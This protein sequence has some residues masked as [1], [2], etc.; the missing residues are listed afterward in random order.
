MPLDGTGG[1]EWA[2]SRVERI[3][4]MKFPDTARRLPLFFGFTADVLLPESSICSAESCFLLATGLGRILSNGIPLPSISS[5][6]AASALSSWDVSSEFCV[7]APSKSETKSAISCT[8]KTLGGWAGTSP[9]PG[10]WS[11]YVSFCWY[12]LQ[13]SS[14]FGGVAGAH[15][16]LVTCCIWWKAFW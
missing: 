11:H 15:N 8:I 16:Y 3:A 9:R 13:A 4:L 10:Q 12:Q 6:M 7:A 1:Q 5:C 2:L 14:A